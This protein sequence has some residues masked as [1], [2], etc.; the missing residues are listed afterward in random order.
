MSK[1]QRLRGSNDKGQAHVTGANN[2]GEDEQ[3]VSESEEFNQKEEKR[4]LDMLAQ[5][6]SQEFPN[7]QRIGCPDPAVLRGI[8]RHELPL[9]EVRRWLDHLSTCSPCFQQSAEFRKEAERQRRRRMAWIASGGAILILIS[10]LWV[11][12]HTHKPATEVLDLRQV[13]AVNPQN[14]IAQEQ[15]TLVL[16]RWA[17][18]LVVDLPAGSKSGVEEEIAVF[19][20]SDIEVFDTTAVTRSEHQLV[21]IEVDVDVS[22]FQTGRYFLGVREPGL[23][24]TEYRVRIP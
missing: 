17:R 21:F 4:L 22:R 14:P 6:L 15:Q 13:P 7:P 20:E 16:Y 8:A 19:S 18:H 11:W 10:A 9:A 3:Q 12:M 23:T 24:W 5:G 1:S 2:P